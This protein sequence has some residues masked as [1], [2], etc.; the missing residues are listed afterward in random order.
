MADYSRHIAKAQRKIAAKGMPMVFVSV[1]RGD[2]DPETDSHP[3]VE[4]NFNLYGV[5]T[6][7]TREEVQTGFFQSGSM[8]VLMAADDLESTPTIA[9]MLEFDGHRWS[10]E[11]IKIVAPAED[12]ILY[13]FQIKDAG[14]V[15]VAP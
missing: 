2:Y 13:K 8:V 3:A 15:E 7:P 1:S 9:D 12:D 6:S 4:T 11:N 10:I 14:T 5:K